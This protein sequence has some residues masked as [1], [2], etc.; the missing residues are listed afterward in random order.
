LNTIKPSDGPGHRPTILIG[1]ASRS[2]TTLMAELLNRHSQIACV[3]ESLLIESDQW[4]SFPERIWQKDRSERMVPISEFKHFLRSS[5]FLRKAKASNT[6]Y[7]GLCNHFNSEQLE[8]S[9]SVIDGYFY[10][11]N[12][13]ESHLLL[14]QFV[15]Q[16][17]TQYASAHGKA[18]WA[19]KTPLN[20]WF[21]D[22]W[23]RCL[24]DSLFIN[25][26][27]DGRDRV[28]SLL[29]VPWWRKSAQVGF[30]EWAINIGKAFKAME[31]LPPNR[32][33]HLRYEDLVLRTEETLS[34]LMSFLGLELEDEMLT[35][36][37]RTNSIGRF[38]DELTPEE[39]SYGQKKYE[40]IF[41]KFRY[42]LV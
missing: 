15:N 21:Y 4:R 9:L 29:K 28:C 23:H 18:L 7:A 34:L 25:M 32:C 24:P 13:S 12:S 16:L 17:F 10:V 11:E 41:R 1:G 40:E 26:I 6:E 30:D 36:K 20:C 33:I 3:I 5:A 42:P 2:G 19:E 38:R 31:G 35:F 27:R 37:M 39:L 14:G 22:F 8:K